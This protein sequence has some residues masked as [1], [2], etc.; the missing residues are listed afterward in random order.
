MRGLCWM[1]GAVL[2]AIGVYWLSPPL[3]P[4]TPPRATPVT[5][6]AASRSLVARLA[7]AGQARRE[8]EAAAV[9]VEA[10]EAALFFD[11]K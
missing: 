9:T 7:E 2:V 11:A 6:R 8:R 3:T 4:P 1:L 10:S 5:V